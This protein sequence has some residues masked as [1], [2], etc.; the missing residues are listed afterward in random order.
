MFLIKYKHKENSKWFLMVNQKSS[1]QVF[2]LKHI[3]FEDLNSGNINFRKKKNKRQNYED[4][5]TTKME[6]K[7]QFLCPI[8]VLTTH[9]NQG[10]NEKPSKLTFVG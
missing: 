7:L 8:L 2:F 9:Y 6:P 1:G 10:L 5:K 3:N 4:A